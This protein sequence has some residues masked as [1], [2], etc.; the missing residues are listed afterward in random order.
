[1]T[2]KPKME[3]SVLKIEDKDKHVLTMFETGP[4]GKEIQTLEIVFTRKK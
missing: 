2:G 4:E 3:R 1:M